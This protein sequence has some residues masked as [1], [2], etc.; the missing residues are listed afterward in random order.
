MPELKIYDLFISHAWR[1]ND[2]YTRLV[3]MLRKA[4]NFNWRNYSDPKHDPVVDPDDK[5]NRDRLVRELEGQIRPTNC[6]IVI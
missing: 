5:V 1:Y 4:P 3:D 2:D 6:V